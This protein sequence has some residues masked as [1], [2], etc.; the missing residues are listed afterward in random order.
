V[1]ERH[2]ELRDEQEQKDR[3]IA[4]LAHE[5]RN[6][7]A[8]IR[9]GVHI[10]GQ[11][12]APA[13]AARTLAIMDRQL[14][15]MVRLID[16]LLDVSRVARGTLV[17]RREDADLQTVIEDAVASAEP[18]IQAGGQHLVVEV[19]PQPVRA[20]LDAART[21]QMLVNLLQNAAKFT[22]PAGLIRLRLDV[23]ED[24]AEVSV[25]DNGRGIQPDQ[26]D[27][28]FDLFYQIRD[29]A[30]GAP[31]GLGIGLSLSRR[32]AQLHGGT[33]KAASDG[34]GQGATFTLRIPRLPDENATTVVPL[35]G[36]A[37]ELTGLRIMVVDDNRDAAETLAAALRLQGHSVS[38][39]H[40]GAGALELAAELH[41]DVV[42]LDIGMPL[43]DGY[44]VCR[45]LRAMSSYRECRIIAVTG[46]GAARD[47]QQAEAAGFDA[48][49]T[50]PAD[51]RQIEQVLRSPGPGFGH[52]SP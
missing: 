18:H 22:P 13:V 5:L 9:T 12:P 16:D 4:T 28:I 43:M 23:T 24:A 11:R 40:D 30:E 38:V 48:H 51:W 39:A 3:F 35:H 47:R 45:R 27:R 52:A 42:L 32:L 2:Q 7:L 26:L 34:P 6:P 41:A 20:H 19:P 25:V 14:S 31:P 46:W 44:E 50:K 1:R 21:C 17:L 15:H 33:L 29:A 37:G 36:G 10:L 8:P 49:V